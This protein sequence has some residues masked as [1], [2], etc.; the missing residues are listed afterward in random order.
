MLRKQILILLV[1]ILQVYGKSGQISSKDSLVLELK[2]YLAGTLQKCTENPSIAD[3]VAIS[4]F[5]SLNERFADKFYDVY[6][7]EGSSPGPKLDSILLQYG[8]IEVDVHGSCAVKANPKTIFGI[9]Q[10]YLSES[11]KAFFKT[12][13]KDQLQP[14]FYD[15]EL[16]LLPW[17]TLAERTQLLDSFCA[18]YPGTYASRAGESYL[19]HYFGIYFP[20]KINGNYSY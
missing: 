10:K 19:T 12:R 9:F 8:I 15:D 18:A 3:S 2:S 1:F 11:G 14:P 20:L 4:C 6:F 13:M 5:D 7:S 17:D 16:I